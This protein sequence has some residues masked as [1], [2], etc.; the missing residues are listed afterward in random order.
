MQRVAL[1]RD[2]ALIEGEWQLVAGVEDGLAM[3]TNKIQATVLTFL[4]DQRV[5]LGCRRPHDRFI[6][7]P[8]TQ[9]PRLRLTVAQ[10]DGEVSSLAGIYEVTE[11][12]LRVCLGNAD[13]PA[14]D[15]ASA[16]GSGQRLWTFRRPGAE[17]QAAAGA[18]LE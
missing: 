16:P 6:L 15:F 4:P 18:I 2:L 9:P 17:K 5:S 7:E 10:P 8:Q 13:R 12:S 14:V 3:P 11:K 1:R